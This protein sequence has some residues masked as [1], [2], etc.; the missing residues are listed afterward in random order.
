[1]IKVKRERD[2][3]VFTTDMS[4]EECI[5][6]IHFC[7]SYTQVVFY[8]VDDE[9]NRVTRYVICDPVGTKGSPFDLLAIQGEDSGTFI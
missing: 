1:M 5:Y 2:G 6:E 7:T 4:K 9:G 8:E 3:K